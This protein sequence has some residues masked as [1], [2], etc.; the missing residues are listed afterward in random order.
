VNA[1]RYFGDEVPWLASAKPLR[2]K[3]DGESLN[4]FL[5]HR[6][7]GAGF[8]FTDWPWNR[9]SQA[10]SIE[11]AKEGRLP[12]QAL[13]P[14]RPGKRRRKLD[15]ELCLAALVQ[16]DRAETTLEDPHHPPWR[17]T[18]LRSGATPAAERSRDILRPPS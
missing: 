18:V 14:I 3:I 4:P 6:Q 16:P 15:D 2:S 13:M 7:A 17:P 12:S 9:E 1:G 11:M 10:L 5:N 8:Y